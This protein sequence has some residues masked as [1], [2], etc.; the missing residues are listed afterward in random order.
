MAVNKQQT[1]G[2]IPYGQCVQITS[3]NGTSKLD[4]ALADPAGT[5]G[6][7]VDFVRI[8]TDLVANQDV[9]FFLYDSVAL[10]T[11]PLGIQAIPANA[12]KTNAIQ[13]FEAMT[14]ILPDSLLLKPGDKLQ[15]AATGAITA[16]KTI[17]LTCLGMSLD[18]H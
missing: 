1:F 10:K 11:N 5:A 13:P 16:G 18:S 6:L 15:V 17:Y 4:L 2:D 8:T 14:N 12:G 3:A 9:E 7:R